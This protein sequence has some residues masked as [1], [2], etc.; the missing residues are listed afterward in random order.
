MIADVL[1]F[2]V[3]MKG[4]WKMCYF[5]YHE[6]SHTILQYTSQHLNKAVR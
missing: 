6:M 4:N 1:I 2:W 3:N 5:H